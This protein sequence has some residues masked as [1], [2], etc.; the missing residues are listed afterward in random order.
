VQIQTL[1]L[2]L[3]LGCKRFVSGLG[4]RKGSDLHGGVGGGRP[5]SLCRYLGSANR[6]NRGVCAGERHFP[7][8]R[9]IL[10]TGG[11]LPRWRDEARDQTQVEAVQHEDPVGA[12]CRPTAQKRAKVLRFAARFEKVRIPS[13]I[14]DPVEISR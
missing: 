13:S 1:R 12:G 2:R 14:S 10:P 6:G 9:T 5:C 4:I 11:F 8:V 3:G 7:S